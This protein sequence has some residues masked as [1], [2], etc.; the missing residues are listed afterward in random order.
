GQLHHIAHRIHHRADDTATH[1]E[2]D[3]HGEVVDLSFALGIDAVEF[4]PQI[5][6]RHDHAAQVH[7]ALQVGGRIGDLGGRL[8]RA[9][10]LH[11]QDVD[12]VLLTS[13]AEGEKFT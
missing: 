12:A 7:D 6:H 4:H 5:D 8:V 2:H 10:F 9:D 3:H 1:I 11:L 13:Q